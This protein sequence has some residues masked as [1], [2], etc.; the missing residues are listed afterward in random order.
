MTENPQ[1]LPG[2][3]AAEISRV[4]KVREHTEAVGR[5][6]GHRQSVAPLLFMLD[7]SLKAAIAAADSPDIIEQ[8]RAVKD[9]EEY[10][11]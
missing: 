10:T 1:T 11:G 9:L 6:T 4:T 7:T 8:I 5:L 2:K 3:L